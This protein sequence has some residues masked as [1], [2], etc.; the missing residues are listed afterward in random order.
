[1]SNVIL[2]CLSA[3]VLL[4]SSL[5]P[6][7]ADEQKPNVVLIL[8]DDLSHY[9]VTAYGANRLS[10]FNGKFK[11][12]TF[13]TPNIDRLAE[14]GM[15]C[16]NAFAY[17][18]CENTRIALMSD[19]LNS[20]NL[21]KVKSQHASDITFG[22][23]FKKAGYTTGIYGKWKQTRGTKEIPGKD[24]ISEFGWDDYCC[25]DVVS[26]NQ[27][28]INPDLVINGEPISF[29]GRKDSDP[30]TGRR[31]YGPDICNR[32]ALEFIDENKDKPFFLYYPMLLVHDDH[33]PTPDTQPHSVFDNFPESKENDNHKYFPDM[34]QY[35]DKL[36]GKVVTKL[37]EHGLRK[38]TLVVVMGDNGTKE[39]F[40]HI[41]PDNSEYPGGKGGN[42][43][44]G[45]HVP[46]VLS[47]PGK[48][49]NKSTYDGLIDVVDI[50]PTITDAAGIERPKQPQIDGISFWPQATGKPGEARKVIY[51]WF[52]GN[53]PASDPSKLLRYAFTKDFKRYA[54]SKLFPKGRFFDLRSDPMEDAG[55]KKIKTGWVHFQS[56]GLPIDEL[57]STQR[58]AY[59]EL[60]KVIAAHDYQS[61]KAIEI[62]SKAIEL[63]K[64]NSTQLEW[65]ILPADATRRNVIWESNKPKIASVDKFG[66]VHAHAPGQAEIT[67]YSWDDAMPQA[68]GSGPSFRR[69]GI[70]SAIPVTVRP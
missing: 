70:R 34:I 22:D 4:S 54:P 2:R 10:H 43:D 59:E 41:L 60:G 13:S 30:A 49:S 37:D 68:T 14:E 18:L 55:D 31:W 61:V 63:S 48:I 33:K 44:N 36:I 21:L 56:S 3:I 52:N 26:E 11:N 62:T 69:D 12:L 65:N 7:H 32:K 5:L 17:P 8:I 19:Q 16:D 66:I 29:K 53:A 9:G 39:P 67:A 6:A 58:A 20:R 25:F 42:K 50:Y 27:R 23:T 15:R 28:F 47:W 38:N 1:M 24:Y 51:T 64:G 46:L 35:M 40:I 57:D 45:L